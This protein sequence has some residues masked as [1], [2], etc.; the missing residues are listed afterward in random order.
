[1]ERPKLLLLED[2]FL[3]RH[4][5]ARSL[6]EHGFYVIASR[7]G[8]DLDDILG[9]NKI[10]I[11]LS[12]SDLD[13]SENGVKGYSLCSGAISRGAISDSTFIVGMSGDGHNQNHWAG[14]ANFNGF[15]NKL[16]FEKIP[17]GLCI[18]N[19]FRVA[20]SNPLIYG[21]KL[22]SANLDLD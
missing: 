16:N 17:I 22:L 7:E 12:D 15:Y 1:M 4:S 5:Y 9:V 13:G 14:I 8:A 11:I 10:E 6:D 21:S 2:D 3:L 19:Y 20:K 18:A